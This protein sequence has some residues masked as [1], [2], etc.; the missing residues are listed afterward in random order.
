MSISLTIFIIIAGDEG[1]YFYIIKQGK[2]EVRQKLTDIDED[3]IVRD[4][5]VNDLTTGIVY[6]TV[7]I[8]VS[9]IV[10]RSYSLT[11]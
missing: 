10:T 5:L 9:I 4:Q 3:T 8:L 7:Y 1:K 11:R 6:L 2:V